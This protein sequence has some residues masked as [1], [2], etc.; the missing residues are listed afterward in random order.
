MERATRILLLA[1]IVLIVSSPCY[2]VE[3]ARTYGGSVAESHEIQQTDDGGYVVTGITMSFGAGSADVWVLKLD[4]QGV[5]EWQKTYG[6]VDWDAPRS[7]Q[8]TSDGGYVVA[9]GTVSFGY[10]GSDDAWVLKLD[11]VGNIEWQ[12]T[13]GGSAGESLTAKQTSDGG[14]VA[15]G[16]THS[17]GAGNSDGWVLKLDSLGNVEWEKTYGGSNIDTLGRG[18]Q[19]ADGG[20]IVATQTESF[21]AGGKDAWIVKLDSVGNIEWQKTYGSGGY[22]QVR[23][24]QQTTDGGYIVHGYYNRGVWAAKLDSLG[25]IEWQKTYSGG[26]DE[27][28]SI[29]QVDSGYILVA[30]NG[31]IWV[32]KLDSNGNIEWEKTYGGSGTDLGYSIEQC[33][34]GGY[35]MAGYTDS[36][37]A[38][39]AGLWVL[40]LNADGEI[41]GCDTMG[42]SSVAVTDTSVVGQNTSVVPQTSSAV[43]GNTNISGQATSAET[44]VICATS[45]DD[46]PITVFSDD[47]DDPITVSVGGCFIPTAASSFMP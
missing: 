5:V 27:A 28:A 4:S 12:R 18:Q 7:C 46:D 44:S 3:W 14:Y 9:G 13:Y 35:V 11:S 8:Q 38:G 10:G 33:F 19:T 21:G 2:A 26:P 25:N 47:D 24:I 32:L 6:G 43:T 31:D 41:P 40:K 29:R 16:L 22:D 34:D 15:M 42:T 17:F 20:Y 45:D 39:S 37:G 1:A 30:F 36:F 23:S